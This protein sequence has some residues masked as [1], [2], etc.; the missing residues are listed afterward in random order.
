MR[1]DNRS[2]SSSSCT[3]TTACA[4]IGPVSI[5]ARTKCTVQPENRTPAASAWRCGCRPGNGCSGPGCRWRR[6]ANCVMTISR[7]R[8]RDDTGSGPVCNELCSELAMA[9]PL[10]RAVAGLF[11]LLLAAAGAPA[12]AA[13][14]DP[15][16]VTISVD[17]TGDTIGKARD[18]ARSDGQRKAL[19]ALVERLS[20]A[21]GAAKL[22]KLD[23]TTLTEL[24]AS[25]KVA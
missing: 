3:G 25:V 14:D 7:L 20:G 19:A 16:S 23:D 4:I 9:L 24:I 8:R 11:L 17:A 12:W 21:K 18:M 5:S 10:T 13:E 6:R 22:P 2:S 15:Y 1:A